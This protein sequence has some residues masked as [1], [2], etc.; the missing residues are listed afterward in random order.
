MRHIFVDMSNLVGG[1][2]EY[3]NWKDDLSILDAHDTI[4]PLNLLLFFGRGKYGTHAVA[5]SIPDAFIGVPNWVLALRKAGFSDMVYRREQKEITV[6]DFLCKKALMIHSTPT[7]T[8]VFITGDGNDGHGY[9]SF[10]DTIKFLLERKNRVEIW[11]FR[12][13][14]SSRYSTELQQY[15]PDFLSVNALDD[16]AQYDSAKRKFQLEVALLFNSGLSSILIYY[17]F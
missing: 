15:F 6:D 12:S 2:M 10:F 16:F 8:F 13:H 7:D 3:F 17:I 5:G 1:A 4:D 11:S 9:G 14:L